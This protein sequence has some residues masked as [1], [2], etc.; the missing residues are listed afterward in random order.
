MS[1]AEQN[2]FDKVVTALH[3]QGG[4]SL[5]NY[6]CSYRGQ[7]GRK[8]AAGHLIA[9][10]DYDEAMEGRTFHGLYNH[11][12]F[13]NLPEALVMDLQAAHDYSSFNG[14]NAE[15]VFT[16]HWG[17]TGIASNLLRVAKTYELDP[18]LVLNC[19]PKPEGETQG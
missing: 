16:R 14:R 8:C 3:Q 5:D 10:C 7:G 1:Q 11:Y 4:P 6:G 18:V 13:F 17:G 12:Y 9:D 15:S 19:W 2:L